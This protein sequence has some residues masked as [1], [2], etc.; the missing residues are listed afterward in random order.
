MSREKDERLC[1]WEGEEEG[2]R[3]NPPNPLLFW[4]DFWILPSM[5]KYPQSYCPF[6]LIYLFYKPNMFGM[7]YFQK[8]SSTV[9]FVKMLTVQWK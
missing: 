2:R 4:S 9:S 7:L 3:K 5:E 1:Y 8:T 6:N